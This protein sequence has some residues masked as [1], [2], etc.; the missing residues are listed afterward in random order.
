[1]KDA[2]KYFAGS[3]K[4]V[5]RT[6]TNLRFADDVVLISGSMNELQIL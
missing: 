2:L 6:I 1:M 3:V 4:F 5:G